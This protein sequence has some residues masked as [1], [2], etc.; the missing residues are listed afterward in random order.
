MG[1]TVAEARAKLDDL[2][3]RGDVRLEMECLT[4][5]HQLLERSNLVNAAIVAEGKLHYLHTM[6][7]LRKC[8]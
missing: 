2:C 5:D 8:R 1:L 6:G 7:E 4:E 3:R